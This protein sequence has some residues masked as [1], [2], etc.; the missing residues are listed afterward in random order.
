MLKLSNSSSLTN[1]ISSHIKFNS[2]ILNLFSCFLINVYNK[3]IRKRHKILFVLILIKLLKL[4][5]IFEA[6]KSLFIYDLT[7]YN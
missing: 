3:L 1:N 6:I 5:L 2:L 4:F 7:Q